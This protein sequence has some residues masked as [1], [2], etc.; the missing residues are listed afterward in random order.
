MNQSGVEGPGGSGNGALDSGG[1]GKKDATRQGD[2]MNVDGQNGA[3]NG[4]NE[5]NNMDVDTG[6]ESRGE[7]SATNHAPSIAVPSPLL[8]AEANKRAAEVEE[9]LVDAPTWFKVSYEFFKDAVPTLGPR[10]Q[11]LVDCFTLLKEENN[12]EKRGELAGDGRPAMLSKWIQYGRLTRSKTMPTT[13]DASNLAAFKHAYQTWYDGLQPDWR[14]KEGEDWKRPKLGRKQQDWGLLDVRGING[15]LSVVACLYWW[16]MVVSEQAQSDFD[17][18]ER[19]AEDVSW[20]MEKMA[21]N[22]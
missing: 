13:L 18:W 5:G 22:G 2:D 14:E 8:D 11:R 20:V 10:W 12:F 21:T 3:S 15:M 4:S 16:G 7:D 1:V 9:A 17:E 6:A 19:A